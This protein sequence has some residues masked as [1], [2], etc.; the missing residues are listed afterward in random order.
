MTQDSFNTRIAPTWCPGCG[1]FGIFTALKKAL[2]QQRLSKDQ[3]L[4]VYDIGC[5]GNMADF[6]NLYGIHALHGRILPVAAGCHL[7]NHQLPVLAIGGDGGVYGEG[8]E[9][10]LQACRSNFNIT[11]LV[12]N[13]QL[14]SLT[15]GQRS[16]TA[17]AGK[18]TKSTPFGVIEEP[19][20]PLKTAILYRA[21]FVARGYALD[22][23]QLAGLIVEAMK[24]EG[25][26]LID[27]LQ[28]CVTFNKERSPEWYQKRIS[29]LNSLAGLSPNQAFKE[30]NQDPEKLV[31]GV[32]YRS[33]R[34]AYHSKLPQLKEKPVV[35]QN[36]ET[37][38]IG[39]IIDGFR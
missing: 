21:G 34:P 15:T 30:L 7:A 8:V 4:A 35:D 36:I 28:P 2:T 33:N 16:P 31:C 32:L 39:S 17:P 10:F 25:F 9:H 3:V 37:I 6:L 13:N 11:L 18:K 23:D 1:N 20:E 19:F 29:K 38:D 27:V 26:A 12:H 5:S 24:Q 14:Y 22:T